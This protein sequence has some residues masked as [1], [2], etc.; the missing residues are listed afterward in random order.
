MLLLLQGMQ[1]PIDLTKDSLEIIREQ[2]AGLYSGELG[3]SSIA[4][5]QSAADLALANLDITGYANKRS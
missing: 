2:F 3:T 4:G 1:I 5:G